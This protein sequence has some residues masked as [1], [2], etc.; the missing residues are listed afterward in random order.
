MSNR[1]S[2][3]IKY[4]KWYLVDTTNYHHPVIVRKH[5]VNKKEA[6]EFRNMH[7]LGFEIIQGKEAFRMN[8]KDWHNMK[9]NHRHKHVSKYDFPDKIRT[10]NQRKIYRGNKR[11]YMKNKPPKL[12]LQ[13]VKD[14]LE[15]K[16]IF[17]IVKRLTKYRGNYW[18]I[19][20]PVLGYSKILKKYNYY[21]DITIISN[22]ARA[23]VKYYDCG[24]YRET[25]VALKIYSYWGE[26]AKRLFGGVDNIPND[27]KRVR[28]EFK[29]RGFIKDWNS[30][31]PWHKSHIESIGLKTKLVYPEPAWHNIEEQK[32]YK[33]YVYDMQERLGI[34]GFTKAVPLGIDS[35]K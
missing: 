15:G 1:I 21:K 17:F 7:Y 30:G 8:I 25:D 19:S 16:P 28:K 31:V 33:E 10:Q 4:T 20:D 18:A 35:R 23:L 24:I 22:I 5:L 6:R 27:L 14:I 12:T 34:P 9:P 11:R 3:K 29:A 26:L 32:L 13:I 2:F